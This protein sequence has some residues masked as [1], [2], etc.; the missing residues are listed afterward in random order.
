MKRIA[1]IA[2]TALLLAACGSG[3]VPGWQPG[4][5]ITIEQ[6]DNRL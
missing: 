6:P 3:P 5:K 1:V 4:Q 2:A